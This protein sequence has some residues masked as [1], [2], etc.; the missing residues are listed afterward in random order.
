M[1]FVNLIIDYFS[2]NGMVQSNQLL[3]SPFI[4]IDSKGIIH[5][6]GNEKALQIVAKVKE[7]NENCLEEVM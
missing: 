3:Q 5:L 7:L 6:F 4:D 2:E 1:Q